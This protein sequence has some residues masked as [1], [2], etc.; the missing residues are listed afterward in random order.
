MH[1]AKQ[2]TTHHENQLEHSFQR[3]ERAMKNIEIFNVFFQAHAYKSSL[4]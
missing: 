3:Q 2:K 4:L 1:L